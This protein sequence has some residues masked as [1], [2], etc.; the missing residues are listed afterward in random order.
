VSRPAIAFID[1]GALQHNLKVVRQYRPDTKILAIIKANAYGHGI[2]KVAQALY[3]ADAFGVACIEEA[4]E[5]RE[6]NISAPI[7]LLS[8]VLTTEE[9]QQA[10]YYHCELVIHSFYQ[11]QM[12]EQNSNKINVW[13]KIDTGMSRLGF[14]PEAV[15]EVW[16]R[17]QRCRS[18]KNVRFM[19]H[20]A[21]ADDVKHPATQQQMAT[22]NQLTERYYVEKSLA[23]SAGILAW[24][25]S[26]HQWVRPGIMLYGIS[27][28]EEKNADSFG[29][30][31]VMTLKSKIIAINELKSGDAVG[32][33]LTWKAEKNQK[34]AIVAIGYGDGYP[35]H[36]KNGTA[37]LVN[38]TI[39]HLAGRVSMDTICVD[40]SNAPHARLGDEVTLW[41][42]GLPIEEV[43]RNASTIAYELVCQIT[44][45]VKFD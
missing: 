38:G 1:K 41:G 19:S 16:Q 22:F 34:I 15:H 4:I 45:R 11:L 40:L 32:Y 26:Q 7:V 29:L 21:N 8:G 9:F 37:V 3:D 31:P 39:C 6:A 24:P 35:R 30:R 2:T 12:L 25:S 27:P 42:E 33:G 10:H 18:V 20:F 14:P 43:A 13:I 36:A 5:L 23:N 44:Q 28:F 17:L